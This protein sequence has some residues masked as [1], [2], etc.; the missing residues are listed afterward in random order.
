M[1]PAHPASEFRP[2]IKTLCGGRRNCNDFL[3]AVEHPKP[4]SVC[5]SVPF[6]AIQSVTIGYFEETHVQMFKV[7]NGRRSFCFGLCI[8]FLQICFPM[9]LAAFRTSCLSFPMVICSIWDFLLLIWDILPRISH[10]ICSIWDIRPFIFHALQNLKGL[11]G[12]LKVFGIRV[13]GFTVYALQA[14]GSRVLVLG[15]G[16]MVVGFMLFTVFRYMV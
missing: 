3:G 13:N 12:S 2:L 4:W 5:H 1:H 8:F 6:C 11:M 7:F 14:D 16:R 9:V 15:I 10:G